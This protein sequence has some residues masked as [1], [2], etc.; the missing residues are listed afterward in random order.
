MT[1]YEFGDVVLVDFPQSGIDETKRRP[2][3]VVLDIGDA[4]VV[5]APITTRERSRRGATG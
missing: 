4:D 5:L 3:L 1:N 2:A